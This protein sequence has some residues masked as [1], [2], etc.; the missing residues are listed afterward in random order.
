MS[1]TRGHGTWTLCYIPDTQRLAANNPTAYNSLMQWV[2]DNAAAEDIRMVIH[3]GDYVNLGS[4]STE[5][6]RTDTAVNRLHG[7]V[8]F[9]HCAGNHDYDDDAKGGTYQRAVTNWDAVFPHSDWTGYSW[10]LGSYNNQTQSMA[11]KLTIGQYSYLF[12]TLE[13]FPRAAVIAWANSII[14]ANPTDRIILGTHA[15]IVPNGTR[16]D[17]DGDIS[18]G[19]QGGAPKFYSVC[20]YRTD[21]DCADG[22]ELYNTFISQHD[23]IILTLNGHDVV[24]TAG[25][26]DHGSSNGYDAYG[27]RTDTVNG[28]VINQHL[29]NF[30]NRPGSS[31]A[32][33][34]FLRLYRFDEGG[35]LCS[36]ETKNPVQ[37]IDL[38]DGENQFSFS[39]Y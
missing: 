23:N 9:I 6:T 8:P 36:V 10:Y 3:I 34:A 33:S 25:L 21:A 37:S 31:Y 19:G 1:A 35:N 39:Y 22:T 32:D 15:Y 29:A 5:W 18:D 28:K 38:T 12:L 2:V 16:E 20:D 24:S 4:S 13:F 26:P 27:R 17:D 11:A 14:A 7:N 30:Q